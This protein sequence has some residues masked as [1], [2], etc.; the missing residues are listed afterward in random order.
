[1][2]HHPHGNLTGLY[3]LMRMEDRGLHTSPGNLGNLAN[4]RPLT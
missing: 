4:N 2:E 1:M 3:R